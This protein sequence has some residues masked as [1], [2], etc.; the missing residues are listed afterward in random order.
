V[1]QK[2]KGFLFWTANVAFVAMLLVLVISILAVLANAP[3]SAI[4]FL[5]LINSG[6]GALIWNEWRHTY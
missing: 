6:W 1:E 3:K 4:I 5:L 2:K